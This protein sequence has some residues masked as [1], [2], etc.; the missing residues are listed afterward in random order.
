VSQ[1]VI[2]RL[3]D[4][5][6]DSLGYNPNAQVGPTALLWPDEGCQWQPIIGRV[7][8]RIPLVSLGDYDPALNQGPAYWVRCVVMRKIAAGL[9]DGIPIVYLPGVGRNE[10]RAVE[11]CSRE[12]APVAELQYRSQWFSHPNG[13]DWTVRSFLSQTERG[14]GLRIAED[15][16]TNNALS[17][18]LEKLID[19]PV[20]RLLHQYL[21]SQFFRELINPDPV[22]MLLDWID[23]ASRLRSGL[24]ESK[25][26]AFV[27]HCKANYTFD[28]EGE[29]GISGARKLAERNGPWAQAWERF[30]ETPGLYRGIPGRLLQA[31]PVQLFLEPVEVWPQDNELAEE[32]LRDAL[33]NLGDEPASVSRIRIVQLDQ[34]HGKRRGWVWAELGMAP[35]A[36]ACEHLVTLAELT[37]LPLA[38]DDTSTLIAAYSQKGWR[39]DDAFLLALGAATNKLDREAVGTAA[40]SMYRP[41]L[42]AAANASQTA[43][44]PMVHADTYKSSPSVSTTPGTVTV[45]VDGL[46]LDIGHRVHQRLQNA[47]LEARIGVCLAALPS[48]TETDKPSL[49]PVSAGSLSAGPDLYAARTSSGA[50]AT[51]QVL[52]SLMG[53][54]DVQVLDLLQTGDPLGTAWTEAGDVDHRG[55]DS[56]VHLVDDLG[57]EVEKIVTRVRELLDA[58]WTR[59]E[60][61]TDHGWVL[62]PGGME[63]V[64]LPVA[65][66][67]IK[68]GRCARLK[69]GAAVSVATVPWFWDEQVRIAI[70]PGVTCFEANKEYEHGGVSPQECIVP[71][72]TVTA[73]A[74]ASATGGP[75]ITRVKW[76]GLLCRVEYAGVGQGV[77]ADLRALPADPKTSIAEKSE[78]ATSSGKISLLVPE[79]EH[80]GERVYLVLVSDDGRV[81][82]QREVVVGE[83]R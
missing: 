54:N 27:Q 82:A 59:V 30:S 80:E 68:K 49:V 22:R 73:P 23:D 29:T 39:V 79:E 43:I 46:R 48:V 17:L 40:R 74:V 32:Q 38:G 14:L 41:W 5:L 50:R 8:E 37:T 61:V 33:N 11:T 67:D 31:K 13:R 35:L 52:R 20:D 19:Y 75:K 18:A 26:A 57:R 70:A 25:W 28:P 69:D 77:K 15:A 42:T 60:I 63:K 62:M 78:E 16:D 58:G 12:L 66:A 24:D 6:V 34:A 47:D 65:T 76:L 10:L 55:H 1:T 83:N 7:R 44:G 21:D 53:E 81:V 9:S 71:R 4:R 3:V 45:F 51:V 36:C 72:L 56:G 64:E 2:D